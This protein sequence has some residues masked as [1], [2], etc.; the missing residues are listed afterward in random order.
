MAAVPN[1]LPASLVQVRMPTCR[2]LR[3]PVA[4]KRIDEPALSVSLLTF[5]NARQI[6]ICAPRGCG[7]AG[8]RQCMGYIDRRM[9]TD[10]NRSKPISHGVMGFA[11][12]LLVR[13]RAICGQPCEVTIIDRAG[14]GLR[15][16]ELPCQVPE[17]NPHDHDFLLERARSALHDRAPQS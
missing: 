4:S 16:S 15:V 3:F 9:I 10:G 2:S 5:A 14:V 7:C 12:E 11:C 8:H 17:S 6:V 13:P 1:E